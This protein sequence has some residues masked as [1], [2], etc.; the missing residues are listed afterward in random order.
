MGRER[1]RERRTTEAT[2]KEIWKAMKKEERRKIYEQAK[3][4]TETKERV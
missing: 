4:R 3:R 1:E 2:K